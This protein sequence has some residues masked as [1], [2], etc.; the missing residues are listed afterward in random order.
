LYIGGALGPVAIVIILVAGN[1]LQRCGGGALL[2]LNEPVITAP[3]VLGDL[4]GGGFLDQ[5]AILVPAII[6]GRGGAGGIRGLRALQAVGDVIR[7]GGRDGTAGAARR[8][9]GDGLAQ[10]VANSVIHPVGDALGVIAVVLEL[11][12]SQA[13]GVIIDIGE[14]GRGIA[15]APMSLAADRP[16]GRVGVTQA[17]NIEWAAAIVTS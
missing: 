7:V 9:G 11:F 17:N 2:D 8:G 1:G 12:L 16:R 5:T 3:A 4:A 10:A 13:F 14:L 15:Q 6:G